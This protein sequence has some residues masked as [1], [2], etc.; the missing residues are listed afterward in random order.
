[1]TKIYHLALSAATHVEVRSMRD[2]DEAAATLYAKDALP[3][4]QQ[5]P[6]IS[7]QGD[8]LY[9]LTCLLCQKNDIDYPEASALIGMQEHLMDWHGFTRD[10]HARAIRVR[11][12]D[13]EILFIWALP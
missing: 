6:E 2:I 5:S 13:D 1:M 9:S 10:D 7:S 11:Y 4:L 12:E 8:R 3:W